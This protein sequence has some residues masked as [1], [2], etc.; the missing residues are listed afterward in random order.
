MSAGALIWRDGEVLLVQPAYK[1]DW[2]I[3]GGVVENDESPAATIVR[4]LKEELGID[5]HPNR[6][7]V[8]DWQA[9]SEEYTEALNLIFEVNLAQ[10]SE[11][12]FRLPPDE[13]CSDQFVKPNHF[14]HFLVNRLASRVRLAIQ[15]SVNGQT[16]Y[17]QG[18]AK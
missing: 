7:L 1:P 15:A 14:D 16:I 5:A 6:L 12:L 9:G 2:E 17:T 10:E 4:E 18:G 11:K 8:I 3:P 13:L